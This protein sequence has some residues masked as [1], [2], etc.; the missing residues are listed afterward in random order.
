MFLQWLLQFLPK[1]PK[2]RI[3]VGLA[4]VAVGFVLGK[5]VAQRFGDWHWSVRQS[6][7]DHVSLEDELEE[8]REMTAQIVPDLRRNVEIVVREEVEIEELQRKLVQEEL[9]LASDRKQILQLR[10][11]LDDG[12]QKKGSYSHQIKLELTKRFGDFQIAEATAKAKREILRGREQTLTK[13]REELQAM[14]DRRQ[15][16]QAQVENLSARIELLQSKKRTN[17]VELD[18][19]TLTRCEQ[20]IQHLRTRLSVA[21]RL[22][23]A[24]TSRSHVTEPL[25]AEDIGGSI[26]EYF[27]DSPAKP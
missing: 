14:L 11:S 15:E 4:V 10:S 25:D 13:S 21:E 19:T 16:L 3:A 12:S 22:T 9:Q 8:A 18:Q 20:I 27:G 7:H 23:D 1:D 6:I 17:D 5:H 26:D 2:D 24:P